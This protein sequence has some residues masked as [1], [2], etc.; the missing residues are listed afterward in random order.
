MPRRVALVG[1]AAL[2]GT[3]LVGWMGERFVVYPLAMNLGV[4]PRTL[5]ADQV[6]AFAT[7]LA[8]GLP[9]LG[10]V[11]ADYGTLG[12]APN[13]LRPA[14]WLRAQ[15][16][17]ADTVIWFDPGQQDSLAWAT[18]LSS[19]LNFHYQVVGASIVVATNR[20][21]DQSPHFAPV[22]VPTNALWRRMRPTAIVDRAADGFHVP[23]SRPPGLIAEGPHDWWR[24]GLHFAHGVAVPAGQYVARF[25]LRVANAGDPAAAL[26][27]LEAGFAFG[28]TVATA[29]VRADQ[30]SAETL[31]GGQPMLVS[32]PFAVDQANAVRFLQLRAIHLGNADVT[33]RGMGL[34]RAD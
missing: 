9:S 5:N 23:R 7:R 34:T 2:V 17:E 6:E 1:L 33:L 11:R 14:N 25:E 30:L 10:A 19:R 22:L 21:L 16:L 32:L 28:P 12:L 31:S 24:Y 26:V 18:W 29:V 27:R 8:G 15:S 20:R 4:E 3:G 13:A